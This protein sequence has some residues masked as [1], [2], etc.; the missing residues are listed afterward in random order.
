[1]TTTITAEKFPAAFYA[2]EKA[3]KELPFPPSVEWQDSFLRKW[4][5]ETNSPRLLDALGLLNDKKTEEA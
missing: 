1:M 3:E 4:A 2:M 5:L